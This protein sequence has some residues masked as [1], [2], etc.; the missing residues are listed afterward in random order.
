MCSHL[1]RDARTPST[2]L[3][4]TNAHFP[5]NSAQE[6][7]ASM[8]ITDVHVSSPDLHQDMPEQTL[9]PG[10]PGMGRGRWE[11]EAK[12]LSWES[13]HPLVSP[14]V[15][16]S[17][18]LSSGACG[19]GGWNQVNAHQLPQ[20][21]HPCSRAQVTQGW[22]GLSLLPQLRPQRATGAPINPSWSH[23][24]PSPEAEEKVDRTTE[25][26]N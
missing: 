14:C 16:V 26:T 23:Q 11:A 8:G 24:I 20:C 19:K 17:L 13:G 9:S 15:L 6:I 22:H 2:M 25:D 1:P 18:G 10:D 12:V 4:P 7:L 5:C 21:H 3:C